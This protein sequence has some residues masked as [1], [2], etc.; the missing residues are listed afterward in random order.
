MAETITTFHEYV[1]EGS[2][3]SNFKD[4]YAG[5]EK[6][7]KDMKQTKGL[8]D[9][10]KNL[11]FLDT[12]RDKFSAATSVNDKINDGLKKLGL[13]DKSLALLNKATGGLLSSADP[14][15]M[16]LYGAAETF[17][18]SI[19]DDVV[20]AIM[21]NIYVPES[22]FI[23]GIKSLVAAKVDPNVRNV[24]RNATL[25]HD[26]AET[27]EWLD[28]YNGTTY[29]INSPLLNDAIIASKNGCF[30]V[31]HYILKQLKKTYNEI[32]GSVAL[33][34]N[35][36]EYK[37]VELHRYE[38]FFNN[39]IRH[40]LVYSYSNLTLSSFRSILSNFPT[41]TPSCLGESDEVYSK[42]ATISSQ[43][44]ETIA[45]FRRYKTV[46]VI[47]NPDAPDK[48][49][50][51]P[52]NKNI[53][54]IY[55]WLAFSTDYNDTALLIHKRLHERLKYKILSTLEEAFYEAQKSLIGSPLGRFIHDAKES[56]LSLIAKY[57]KET[58]PYLFDPR[59]QNSLV[60]EDRITLP[61]FRPYTPSRENDRLKERAL[62]KELPPL[63]NNG[64]AY[65]DFK[66]YYVDSD[67]THEQITRDSI[68]IAI[69]DKF[70]Y[71]VSK[72]LEQHSI[73]IGDTKVSLALFFIFYNDKFNSSISSSDRESII[74]NILAKYIIDIYAAKECTLEM[75]ASI[76]PFLNESGTLSKFN[77]YYT[78]LC[79][80][81]ELETSE[82]IGSGVLSSDSGINR[83]IED[84][85]FHTE[86][87]S[88]NGDLVKIDPT[89]INIYNSHG[90]KMSSF[91]DVQGSPVG[92]SI[93]DD[94][95]YVL[96]INPKSG[97]KE[98]YY[99]PDN[100]LTW[101]KMNV[102]GNDGSIYPGVGITSL[103]Q[104]NFYEAIYYN[105]TFFK[106]KENTIVYSLDKINWVNMNLYFNETVLGICIVP[107]GTLYVLTELFIYEVPDFSITSDS[108][109]IKNIANNDN[110]FAV[111]KGIIG[112]ILNAASIP[113]R[114]MDDFDID[115]KAV[116]KKI[117]LY[118]QNNRLMYYWYSTESPIT[119]E[120]F[121]K[122]IE[123]LQ[124]QYNVT[125]DPVK[126][127]EI[128][129]KIDKQN[130]YISNLS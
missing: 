5:L 4:M 119:I 45:P 108:S 75:I 122:N 100:G 93:I 35:D 32:K 11:E 3:L 98:V 72:T 76:Y 41:F 88:A 130:E 68:T 64:L 56:Y 16:S 62:E 107:T 14:F 109:K 36:E 114:T 121:Q 29:D 28:G 26:L 112:T 101:E 42:R 38:I 126:K 25:K 89:G 17:V 110:S 19:L 7:G 52:R 23:L 96:I 61:D 83:N 27:L 82:T 85:P 117:L 90:E 57:V 127:S 128:Q 55:I 97:N 12:A 106:I 102:D 48:V 37:N 22:V 53:K 20:S 34:E 30:N 118:Y 66:V 39:V 15:I 49:F 69:K 65:S 104:L 94:D 31:S 70:P 87:I 120:L 50:I 99:S 92:I 79:R 115:D 113:Y 78:A 18:G 47:I 73:D 125:D 86:V 91:H 43:E 24:L 67:F 60:E 81:N 54:L 1:D 9:S 40:I 129:R 124:N 33:T 58:E 21:A 123:I 44:I 10:V 105:D 71:V 103:K 2:K 63:G 111:I 77:N 8:V 46:E 84:I 95:T 59:N 74:L 116:I 6:A 13:T 51:V 80:F